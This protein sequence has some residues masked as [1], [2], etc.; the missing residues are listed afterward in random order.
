MGVAIFGKELICG[1][2]AETENIPPISFEATE[3]MRSL[4]AVRNE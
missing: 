2:G 3:E 4:E 1:S